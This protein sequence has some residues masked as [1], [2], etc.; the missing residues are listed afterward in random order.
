M[1]NLYP[2]QLEKLDREG[3]VVVEKLLDFDEDLQPIIDEYTQLIDQVAADLFARGT[4]SST[5]AGL[6]FGERLAKLYVE[7]DY[8]TAQ[9]FDISLPQ[10][11]IEPDTPFWAGPEAFGLLRNEKL[12]DAVESV[13]GP[14]I[15]SNPVQHVRMKP[16][17]RLF[18]E[19]DINQ[20][21]KATQWHQ[22]AGVVRPEADDTDML[23]VWFPLTPSREEHGCIKLVPG[24][25][26]IDLLPH[27]FLP[28]KSAYEIP[29]RFFPEEL[30]VPVPMDAGDVL[31]MHRLTCHGSLANTSD[32]LRWSFDLR[33]S[34]IGHPTG[35]SEFPGFVARSRS[36]P[37]SE[38]CDPEA[39]YNMWRETRDRLAQLPDPVYNRWSESNPACA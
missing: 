36:N 17:E 2:E 25:H 23:T 30:T 24:S 29:N 37:E 33:Y 28:K 13:I 34:P 10:K 21:V 18:P 38:L 35:R 1:Q 4:I 9:Y 16:P 19:V 32:Q 22:D 39:W 8:R 26:R 14:E 20:L 15:Y 3:Y 31:F 6:T 11:G 7:S 5:Y 27:C 12:L